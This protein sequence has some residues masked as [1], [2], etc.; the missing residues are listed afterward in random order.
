L[1]IIDFKDILSYSMILYVKYGENQEKD[2]NQ[3]K[4]RLDLNISN[5]KKVKNKIE[6]I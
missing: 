1:K 5:Y 2:K 3:K 4:K 6:S